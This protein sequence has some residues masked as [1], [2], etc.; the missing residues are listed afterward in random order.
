[1]LVFGVP[2]MG[3]LTRIACDRFIDFRIVNLFGYE[4]LDIA[5]VRAAKEERGHT[6]SRVSSALRSAPTGFD[7]EIG[8]RPGAADL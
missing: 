8:S 3:P 2:K 1:M 6:P 5:G 4:A 7:C